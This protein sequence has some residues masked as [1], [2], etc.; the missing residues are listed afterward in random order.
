MNPIDRYRN[1]AYLVAY[2]RSGRRPRDWKHVHDVIDNISNHVNN[3]HFF[4]Y[5]IPNVDVVRKW[6]ERWLMPIL[7]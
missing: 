6:L 7:K 5:D 2:A 1:L 4:K 3:T